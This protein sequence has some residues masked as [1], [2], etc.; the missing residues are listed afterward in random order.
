MKI[1][2]ANLFQPLKA[3]FHIS[4]FT[5]HLSEMSVELLLTLRPY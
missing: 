2:Q 1:L 3:L 4:T 5:I